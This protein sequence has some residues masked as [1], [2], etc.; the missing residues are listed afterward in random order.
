MAKRL[1]VALI[2]DLDGGE[3]ATTVRFSVGGETYEIDLSEVNEAK[4]HDA[5]EPFV[6]VARKLRNHG[7]PAARYITAP[8]RRERNQAIRAWARQRGMNPP[9]RG[10]LATAF[11][12]A[13][14][15]AQKLSA[16]DAHGD[17][18]PDAG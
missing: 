3:A 4:L 16:A 18:A 12:E 15:V 17:A 8:A 10:R 1:S 9:A 7:S 11:I 13:Y 14:E 2:D 5:L 6:A